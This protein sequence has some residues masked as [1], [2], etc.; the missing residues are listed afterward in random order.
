MSGILKKLSLV[1]GAAILI[2]VAL[3]YFW[4]GGGGFG[5]GVANRTGL[6]IPSVT[7]SFIGHGGIWPIG[8]VSN[9]GEA[10]VGGLPGSVPDSADVTWTDIW[11]LNHKQ[12]VQIT[13]LPPPTRTSFAGSARFIYF[14]IDSHGVVT[15]LYHSPLFAE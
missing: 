8:V 5:F 15:V 1:S 13:P 14:V 7:V 6:Q 4:G 9:G 12:H 10:V 2:L 3:I 11:G